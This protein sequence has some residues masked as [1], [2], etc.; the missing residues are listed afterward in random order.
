[1]IDSASQRIKSQTPTQRPIR[2]VECETQDAFHL[3]VT[4]TEPV[5]VPC[6]MHVDDR[7]WSIMNQLQGVMEPSGQINYS[8]Q[9]PG[10]IKAWHRHK[11]QT[12]FW[13]CLHST[14]KV[15]VFRE[16]DNALWELVFGEKRPGVLVIPPTLWHGATTVGSENAGLL[17]YVTNAYDPKHPDEERRA[18]DSVPGFQWE[19]QHR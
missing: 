4:L 18:P 11:L 9:Y 13:I 10:V 1:M 8:T 5:F 19:V 16:T 15:G 3:A 14:L 6:A 7:G 17:Y 2:I 12:D